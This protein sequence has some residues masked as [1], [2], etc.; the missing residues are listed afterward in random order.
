MLSKE[1]IEKGKE[2]VSNLGKSIQANCK[3]KSNTFK[4]HRPT[5]K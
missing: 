5:R 1:E 4:I 2:R 3:E